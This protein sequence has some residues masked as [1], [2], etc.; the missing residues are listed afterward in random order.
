MDNLLVSW[1]EDSALGKHSHPQRR[2]H[3]WVVEN[4]VGFARRRVELE[5]SSASLV[6]DGDDDVIRHLVPEE[7]DL[8]AVVHS[9]SKLPIEVRRAGCHRGNEYTRERE[10]D[11]LHDGI[12]DTLVSGVR[13]ESD[14]ECCG[15][16]HQVGEGIH[17]HLAHDLTSVGL[18]CDLA[19]TELECDL[20]VEQAGDD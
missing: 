20:F 7:L 14:V 8:D 1:L 18:H 10:R 17:L 5:V 11:L 6:R 3:V 13:D 4:V 16:S 19:D 15:H 2:I 12:G 9:V